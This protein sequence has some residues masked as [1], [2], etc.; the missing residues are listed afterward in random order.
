MTASSGLRRRT[1]ALVLLVLAL[2]ILAALRYGRMA[3]PAHGPQ[4][5]RVDEV[6]RSEGGEEIAQV[7]GTEAVA[8]RQPVRIEREG[9]EVVL[10][11]D[12]EIDLASLS[13]V[14]QDLDTG[15][16]LAQRPLDAQGIAL[17]G[18]SAIDGAAVS[19]ESP[20]WRVEVAP[21]PTVSA[22]PVTI[23]RGYRG[24]VTLR[25]VR[26]GSLTV[27]VGA[28]L[29]DARYAVALF[30]L[31]GEGT[32]VPGL[33]AAEAFCRPGESVRF[34]LMRAGKVCVQLYVETV[35]SNA[36][37]EATVRVTPGDDVRVSLPWTTRPT[38]LTLVG[39]GDGA[40][41]AARR[42]FVQG[43]EPFSA[44]GAT[45]DALKPG[46]EQSIDVP[47]PGV[48]Q[49]FA[50]RA[51]GSG[52]SASAPWW[53][54]VVVTGVPAH[55]RVAI[56]FPPR[57]TYVRFV[58][59]QGEPARRWRVSAYRS[60]PVH[61]TA[62]GAARDS[63]GARS[64]DPLSYGTTD[65]DGVT[66]MPL[67]IAQAVSF[68]ATDPETMTS[69]TAGPVLVEG[70]RGT[71]EA[72]LRV[73]VAPASAVVLRLSLPD[74]SESSLPDLWST[75]TLA[76]PD[77]G[78]PRVD[79]V[80]VHMRSEDAG[81]P[82]RYVPATPSGAGTIAVQVG[83]ECPLSIEVRAVVEGR[84]YG[85]RLD[86]DRHDPSRVHQV[87]MAPAGGLD[88]R[89]LTDAGESI[90]FQPTL[91]DPG[92]ERY[93]NVGSS[94]VHRFDHRLVGLRPGRWSILVEE[95]GGERWVSEVEVEANVVRS[96][97]LGGE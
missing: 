66:A 85:G 31:R 95:A 57:G 27:D 75:S 39:E 9:L 17:F 3:R 47:G 7:D 70:R 22:E 56:P 72:P 52:A 11:A 14:L 67:P 61:D 2:T 19:E 82:W 79:S 5:G 63:F 69:H 33:H 8:Q 43:R 34:P 80:S 38:P 87:S 81:A 29:P 68:V 41:S 26:S 65:G 77:G 97:L 24:S 40:G 35:S 45:V 62:L 23:P 18:A 58:D 21:N 64:T 37:A 93:P 50:D 46:D 90:R 25:A 30:N 83:D 13:V 92:G 20:L 4:P 60:S 84:P 16:V 76:A 12:S 6:G 89:V 1:M 86:L 96:V 71:A 55:D 51:P 15:A 42:V 59:G 88:L 49:V 74:A 32:K 73:E 10:V 48:Y 54:D 28:Q 36:L 94:S 53:R 91:F 78:F 44:F